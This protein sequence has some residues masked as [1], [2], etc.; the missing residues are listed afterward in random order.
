MTKFDFEQLLARSSRAAAH[1][2]GRAEVA[3]H[4]DG[5]DARDPILDHCDAETIAVEDD[6]LG[7]NDQ[8]HGAIDP[9]L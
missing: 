3:H 6:R 7:R 5:T 2:D 4:I 8:E 9:R 1:L